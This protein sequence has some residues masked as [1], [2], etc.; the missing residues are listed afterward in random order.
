MKFA[1]AHAEAVRRWQWLLESVYTRTT[2]QTFLKIIS[3]TVVK[4]NLFWQCDILPDISSKQIYKRKRNLQQYH[5][6]FIQPFKV[7]F[8]LHSHHNHTKDYRG[9]GMC[10]I[11]NSKHHIISM[12]LVLYIQNQWLRHLIYYSEMIVIACSIFILIKIKDFIV[13]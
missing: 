12:M 10:L 9:H 2:H 1:I 5:T 3:K 7:K 13:N 6:V 11:K 8:I 4:Q